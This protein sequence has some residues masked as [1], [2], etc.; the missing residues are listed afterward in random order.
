MKK[1]FFLFEKS[2]NIN[3]HFKRLPFIVISFP[4]ENRF[5]HIIDIEILAV[6]KLQALYCIDNYKK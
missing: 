5:L 1:L 6:F 2:P 3:N 4:E